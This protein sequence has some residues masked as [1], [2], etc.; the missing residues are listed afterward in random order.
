MDDKENNHTHS[1]ESSRSPATAVSESRI[2]TRNTSTDMAG[3]AASSER[4]LGYGSS[5]QCMQFILLPP[6]LT[7]YQV[8][9]WKIMMH[10]FHQHPFHLKI[11]SSTSQL[12]ATEAARGGSHSISF[13]VI[14]SP[15]CHSLQKRQDSLHYYRTRLQAKIQFQ[16]VKSGSHNLSIS[17][18]IKPDYTV[19]SSS[20]THQ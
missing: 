15:D 3:Y 10:L 1:S 13:T 9:Y 6:G 5:G 11:M 18:R 14:L 17:C 12:V 19:V 4:H 20:I 2:S 16:W 8:T 7:T